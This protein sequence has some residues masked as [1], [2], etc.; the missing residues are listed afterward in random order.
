MSTE[1]EDASATFAFGTPWLVEQLPKQRVG[2]RMG[3]WLGPGLDGSKRPANRPCRD[4]PISRCYE[5]QEWIQHIDGWRLGALYVV[6][7][8]LVARRG[9]ISEAGERRA[10]ASGI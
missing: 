8:E 5:G 1:R 2:G 9:H 10:S 6:A 4:E 3:R 7:R